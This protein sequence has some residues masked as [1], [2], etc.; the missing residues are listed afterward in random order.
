MTKEVH[1][2]IEDDVLFM[3]E[4]MY[5]YGNVIHKKAVIPKDAFIACY[6]KWVLPEIEK[7]KEKC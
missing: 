1:F 4:P 5:G 6:K 7:D 3:D 2:Y